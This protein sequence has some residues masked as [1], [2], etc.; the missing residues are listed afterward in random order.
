MNDNGL[1]PEIGKLESDIEPILKEI[2]QKRIEME[3]LF[4]EITSMGIIT[5]CL[6][7]EFLLHDPDALVLNFERRI[8][9]SRHGFFKLIPTSSIERHLWEH[10]RDILEAQHYSV[11]LKDGR[12]LDRDEFLEE[13]IEEGEIEVVD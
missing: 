1:F 12:V 7:P 10:A 5:G 6:Q 4:D 11:K 8:K 9:G 13:L 3:A 2:L